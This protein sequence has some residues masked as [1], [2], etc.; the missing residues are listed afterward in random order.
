M[1]NLVSNNDFFESPGSDHPHGAHFGLVD[2][3]VR[4]VSQDIDPS[5]LA[6][7]GSIAD[8]ITAQLPEP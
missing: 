7:L 4:F 2:G 3:G 1:V 5:V 8:G 6:L